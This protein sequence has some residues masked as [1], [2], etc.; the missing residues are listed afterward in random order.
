MNQTVLFYWYGRFW[1]EGR[2]KA[3]SWDRTEPFFTDRIITKSIWHS[4]QNAMEGLVFL[5]EHAYQGNVS[6]TIFCLVVTQSYLVSTERRWFQS[7]K[8]NIILRGESWEAREGSIISWKTSHRGIRS[9]WGFHLHLKTQFE[10][11]TMS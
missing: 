3:G 10:A 5:F 7:L 9:F 2:L 1:V 6:G 8:S 4:A 11:K